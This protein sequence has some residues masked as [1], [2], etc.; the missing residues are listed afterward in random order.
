MDSKTGQS[1]QPEKNETEL[2]FEYN[3]KNSLANKKNENCISFSLRFTYLKALDKGVE[4]GNGKTG[5]EG[6]LE[7]ANLSDGSKSLIKRLLSSVRKIIA[8]AVMGATVVAAIPNTQDDESVV[9]IS[10]YSDAPE[11]KG[12]SENDL[13]EKSCLNNSPNTEITVF[14]TDK[15]VVKNPNANL[16][17]SIVGGEGDDNTSVVNTMKE[18]MGFLESLIGF[19]EQIDSKEVQRNK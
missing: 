1:D 13:S 10:S 12:D 16:V 5:D 7:E 15:I 8:G 19:I 17:I 18:C 4:A 2:L 6:D 11:R 9:C 14:D 3:N